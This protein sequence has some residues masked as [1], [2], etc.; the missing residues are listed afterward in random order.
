M[1]PMPD[2][3]R[4]LSSPH[5]ANRRVLGVNHP[6]GS[7]A[8][9]IDSPWEWL[10]EQANS[11]QGG[12]GSTTFKGNNA[13][14]ANQMFWYDDMADTPSPQ[15]ICNQQDLVC[16]LND[17]VKDRLSE[18]L[19]QSLRETERQNLDFAFVSVDFVQDTFGEFLWGSDLVFYT[20]YGNEA[21]T[22]WVPDEC[23][24]VRGAKIDEDFD[25]Y[26]IADGIYEFLQEIADICEGQGYRTELD[27]DFDNF[28][29]VD[30]GAVL[31]IYPN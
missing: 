5:A 25:V 4:Q 27:V 14:D 24:K 2:Y 15:L 16:L 22:V 28:D 20:G 30:L 10:Y 31:V 29:S 11:Y 13:Q 18:S 12:H 1:E 26:E 6:L 9:A 19:A 23:A 8:N 3:I 21:D 7:I 17:D